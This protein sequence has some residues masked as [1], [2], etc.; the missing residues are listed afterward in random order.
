[1]LSIKRKRKNILKLD[2][3]KVYSE[4]HKYAKEFRQESED[5][6]HYRTGELKANIKMEDL[7][8]SMLVFADHTGRNRVTGESMKYAFNHEAKVHYMEI[9]FTHCQMRIIG[10]A[11]TKMKTYVKGSGSETKDIK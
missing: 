1:M 3:D 11:K 7:G 4:L 2:M 10:E 9:G 6:A 8:S 5:I